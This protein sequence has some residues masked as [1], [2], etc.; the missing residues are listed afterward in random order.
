MAL[1]CRTLSLP[2]IGT[3]KATRHL[4][5]G[6]ATEPAVLQRPPGTQHLSFKSQKT[7]FNHGYGY[8]SGRSTPPREGR[9]R[10]FRECFPTNLS[11][12]WLS[13]PVSLLHP[14]M[15]SETAC[16]FRGQI[17]ANAGGTVFPWRASPPISA[18]L[19]AE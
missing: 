8:L 9:A 5:R 13:R 15:R 2:E 16:A 10:R 17:L 4:I 1:P 18:V 12:G 7:C 14:P 11:I 6:K 19:K 3:E